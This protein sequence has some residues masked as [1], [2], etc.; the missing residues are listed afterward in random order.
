MQCLIT[1]DPDDIFRNS[2]FV[3][4]AG[5]SLFSEMYGVSRFIMDNK[6]FERIHHYFLKEMEEEIK[7]HGDYSEVLRES[8]M[9]KAFRAMIRYDRYKKIR[10]KV[11]DYFR[12]RIMVIAL[13]DDK[14]IPLKG[15]Q[16][17][18]GKHGNIKV[19][20]FKFPYIHENPFPV[21][22]PDA[23]ELVD[24]AFSKV[25]TRSAAFLA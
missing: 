1:A 23:R 14:V 19:M 10:D 17:F 9:G 7:G 25:F 4:F 15:I 20:H 6:A 3:F 5:G 12:P 8:N 16:D 24:K 13:R 11:M 21:H 22:I 2:K 18:F